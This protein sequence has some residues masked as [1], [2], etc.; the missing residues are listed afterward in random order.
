MSKY[1]EQLQK[2][3]G[4]CVENSSLKFFHRMCRKCEA[5]RACL[6]VRGRREWVRRRNWNYF[7][8]ALFFC[9]LFFT[10][11]LLIC[12]R[13]LIG[14]R[15]LRVGKFYN[16]SDFSSFE[17]MGCCGEAAEADSVQ[18]RFFPFLISL[19]FWWSRSTRFVRSE[20]AA[21]RKWK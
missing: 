7:S 18:W 3:R 12:K 10:H 2:R 15:S 17:W 9:F 6:R 21:E 19:S 4:K 1:M 8:P 14:W 13:S 11:F 5:N 20:R 16:Q